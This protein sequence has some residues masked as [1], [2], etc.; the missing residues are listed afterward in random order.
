MVDGGSAT[1]RRVG[2][3]VERGA[4]VAETGTLVPRNR[5]ESIK[6]AS[7]IATV[8]EESLEQVDEKLGMLDNHKEEPS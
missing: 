6:E 1:G 4:R 7:S 5:S 3:S 8:G 2:S